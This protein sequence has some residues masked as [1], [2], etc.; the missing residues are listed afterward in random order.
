MKI[1]K[2]ISFIIGI[3]L[4]LQTNAQSYNSSSEIEQITETLM[5]YILGSTHGQ[6]A[7]LKKAFHE[8]L[9]LYY[10]KNDSLKVWA[11][12]DYISDTKEGKPTGE[13]GR[14]LSIDYENNAA[15]AKV[16]VSNPNY[17]GTYIDYFMLLKIE[18]HWKIIHKM[19]TRELTNKK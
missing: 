16:E 6:P 10:I 11:G 8:D 18:G 2:T 7:R 14:I 12:T 3:I 5:D 15:V 4:S 17:P 1:I 13:D 19:F 9:N